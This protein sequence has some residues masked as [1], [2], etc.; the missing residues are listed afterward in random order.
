MKRF[1]FEQKSPNATFVE[2]LINQRCKG[3]QQMR[4][5]R[6]GL[7]P[8]LQL[9]IAIGSNDWN[10]CWRCSNGHS[11]KLIFYISSIIKK[12]FTLNITHHIE[13]SIF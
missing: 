13:T 11:K 3:G 6:E 9:R 8:I 10:N 5:F 4:W 2:S 7:N 12:N 1:Q